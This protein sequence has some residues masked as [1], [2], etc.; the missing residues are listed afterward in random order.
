MSTEMQKQQKSLAFM[1]DPGEWPRW[2]IL[3]VKR[4]DA[5]GFTETGLMFAVEEVRF[6]VYRGNMFTLPGPRISDAIAAC[7]VIKEYI[8]LE[9]VIDDGWIVD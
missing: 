7:E 8:D 6:T 5:N 4:H 2:P 1:N 9:G 3:P